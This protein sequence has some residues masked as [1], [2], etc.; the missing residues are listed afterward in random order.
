MLQG[1]I[2]AAVTFT[3]WCYFGDLVI[4]LFDNSYNVTL[5]IHRLHAAGQGAKSFDRA[6]LAV[7]SKKT[8]DRK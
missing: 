3:A 5:V 1:R 8:S 4:C 6:D 2:L 7:F